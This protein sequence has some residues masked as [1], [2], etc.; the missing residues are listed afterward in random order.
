MNESTGLYEV[1]GLAWGQE[2]SI[3]AVEG[4]FGD[5]EWMQASYEVVDGGLAALQ[6]FE[7]VMAFDVDQLA[8]GNQTLEV[9]GI[10][11]QGSPSLSV[12]TTVVG[13]GLS[14]DDSAGF[15]VQS[16][17]TTMGVLVF[18]I[19]LGLMFNARADE[20]IRLHAGEGMKAEEHGILEA[21]LVEDA[22]AHQTDSKNG[23][24]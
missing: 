9:R 17:L 4:R 13:T 7:W 1:R 5:G 16:L 19:L 12:F 2:G 10:N 18:I 6:R 22:S 3:A 23:T 11:E 15:S 21:E 14:V 24:S 8:K 20:P